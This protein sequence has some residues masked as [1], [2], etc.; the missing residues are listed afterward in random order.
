MEELEDSLGV[1]EEIAQV[2]DAKGWQAYTIRD[3]KPLQTPNDIPALTMS[4]SS[5]RDVWAAKFN[6]TWVQSD[7]MKKQEDPDFWS[8]AF[9]RLG[10]NNFFETVTLDGLWYRLKE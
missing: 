7:E 9:N 8:R 1:G 4:L 5:L 3:S 2:T 6:T 10:D